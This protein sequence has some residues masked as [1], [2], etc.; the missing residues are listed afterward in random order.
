MFIFP[1]NSHAE[2]S[3]EREAELSRIAAN[4]GFSY[5]YDFEE[6]L[7]IF[8]VNITNM[9]DDVYIVDSEQGVFRG[10]GEKSQKYNNG[11]SIRFDI[12]SNDSSC[13]GQKIL[14]KYVNLPAYNH[15]RDSDECQEYPDFEY[16][17][18]WATSAINGEQFLQ[19]FS[20]YKNELTI[21]PNTAETSNN[22]LDILRQF[23]VSPKGILT[24]VAIVVLILAILG[25][26]KIAVKRR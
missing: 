26:K 25:R 13:R 24:L 9:T 22:W 20:N 12:Y 2:C 17:Q 18:L 8:T 10:A 11:T 19:E 21:K 16:C 4:I 1:L 6:V 14:T 5:T 3:Y 23:F 15:Y 7:P